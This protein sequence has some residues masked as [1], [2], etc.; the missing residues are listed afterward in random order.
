MNHTTLVY[1]W[2]SHLVIEDGQQFEMAGKQIMQVRS[3][4]PIDAPE[5]RS[6]RTGFPTCYGWVGAEELTPITPGD[7]EQ[8]RAWKD[9][10]RAAIALEMDGPMA[11]TF[12]AMDQEV[13]LFIRF[14]TSM[15]AQVE[16][17]Q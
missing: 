4:Y 3:A 5:F 6:D 13:R 14:H 12:A 2:R 10:Q 9:A 8:Y 11:D 16:A 7:L 15:V 17:A 1:T